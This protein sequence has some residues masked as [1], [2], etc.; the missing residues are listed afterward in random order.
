MNRSIFLAADLET[1]QLVTQTE[2]SHWADALLAAVSGGKAEFKRDAGGCMRPEIDGVRTYFGGNFDEDDIKAK[3]KVGIELTDRFDSARFCW[4]E[5]TVDE[6]GF[7][8][9]EGK[10]EN[11]LLDAVTYGR[12]AGYCLRK[13]DALRAGVEYDGEEVVV[14]SSAEDASLEP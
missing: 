8:V 3:D 9:C 2:F 10:D 12:Q 14:E 6:D 4:I 5:I 11:V 1:G 7:L 13:E